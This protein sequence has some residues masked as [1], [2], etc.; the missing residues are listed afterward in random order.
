MKITKI[1]AVKPFT[2]DKVEMTE[3]CVED[4]IQA[5]RMAGRPDGYEFSLAVMSVSCKFDGVGQP[6]EELRKMR[7]SDFL[8]LSTAING[9]VAAP[10]TE[11]EKSPKG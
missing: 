11:P 4:F 6:P 5:E 7:S 8:E 2:F 10:T 9:A 3:T 1:A